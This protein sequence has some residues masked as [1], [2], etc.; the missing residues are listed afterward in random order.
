MKYVVGS[1]ANYALGIGAD[2]RL[3]PMAEVVLLSTETHYVFGDDNH[4]RQTRNAIEDTRFW[5]SVDA[6]DRMI[7]DFQEYRAALVDAH[8]ELLEKLMIAKAATGDLAEPEPPPEAPC[9]GKTAADM[10]ADLR[11][12]AQP[13]LPMEI[14]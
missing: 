11:A 3:S 8:D 4:V 1:A 13:E 10:E 5:M 2:G 6:L 14:I 9:D 12:E 7:A